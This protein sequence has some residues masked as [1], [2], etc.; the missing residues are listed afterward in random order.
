VRVEVTSTLHLTENGT[1]VTTQSFAYGT[2]LH[3]TVDWI[4]SKKSKKVYKKKY[5][6]SF[7]NK[8]NKKINL[9]TFWQWFKP[10]CADMLCC[11]FGIS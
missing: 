6:K 3:T 10:N 2:T 5:K 1:F 8:N 9:L 4:N 11:H 7:K